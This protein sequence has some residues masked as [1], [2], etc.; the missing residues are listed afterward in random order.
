MSAI[1]RSLFVLAIASLDKSFFS[2]PQTTRADCLVQG[3]GQNPH[4]PTDFGQMA[5]KV[6]HL[7][8]PLLKGDLRIDVRDSCRKDGNC[9]CGMPKLLPHSGKKSSLLHPLLPE[10]NHLIS[11][12]LPAY[13]PPGGDLEF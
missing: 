9:T 11:V 3:I 2:R 8:I 5:I 7:S 4:L 10:Q 13:L 12:P 1:L 6:V